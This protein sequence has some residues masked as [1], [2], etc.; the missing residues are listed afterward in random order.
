MTKSILDRK[1][2]ENQMKNGSSK[3]KR[4]KYTEVCLFFYLGPTEC[5]LKRSLFDAWYKFFILKEKVLE[6]R[7]AVITPKRVFRVPGRPD[8][9]NDR[10]I[11]FEDVVSGNEA[12]FRFVLFISTLIVPLSSELTI[13]YPVNPAEREALFEPLV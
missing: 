7:A 3:P 8:Q 4:W 2:F 11:I 6:D 13:T 10:M 9:F 12:L 1:I 5:A